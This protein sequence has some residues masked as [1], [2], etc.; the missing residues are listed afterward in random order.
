MQEIKIHKPKVS[1][2]MPT[3]NREKMLPLAIDSVLG[4]TFKDFEFIIVNDG[5]TDTSEAV[6]NKYDDPRIIYVKQKNKGEYPATNVGLRIAMSDYI[7]WIHSDDIMPPDSIKLRVKTL[8]QNPE[9][10]FVHGDIEKIDVAGNKTDRLE[11]IDSDGMTA[12]RE[13]Y[14]I[15]EERKPRYPVHHTTIMFRRPFIFKVG[16]WDETLPYAGDTDWLLRALKVGRM[17]KIDEVLYW[18]RIHDNARSITD[19]KGGV[20]TKKVVDEIKKR[21][22]ESK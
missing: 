14:K 22:E 17:K 7:T 6:I 12:F 3:Y 9:I 18:Y 8:D 20:D 15:A 4:Q 21:Y 16:Y 10:D 19:P 13:Y 5:S 1:I 2:V 11:A